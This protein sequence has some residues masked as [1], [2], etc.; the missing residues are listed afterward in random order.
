MNVL[1][2]TQLK[3]GGSVI[4][5]D[6]SLTV[7]FDEI[8]YSLS[9]GA[10][11]GGFHHTLGVRNQKLM[12]HIETE[13]DLPGGSAAKYM[14]DEMELMGIPVNFATAI[15]TSA[16]MA[17]HVYYC[18]EVEDVIV[19]VILTAGYDKTAHRAGDGYCYEE[20]NGEFHAPGTI[21]MLLFTNKALTDGAMAKA[22]ITIAEA[23]SAVLSSREVKDVLTGATAT[24]TAT[25][26][27]ILTIDTNG[28]ILTDA[29]TF[30]L[31]GDTLA[32]AVREALTL[33]LEI[34]GNDKS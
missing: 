28:E 12:Y 32:K 5:T 29:G 8:H 26:G 30:S 13:K 7:M 19:E 20:R 18:K 24:G 27:I 14:G 6:S 34:Y 21:N 17:K 33:S 16:D 3:T 15:M 23:K 31:F 25:D 22:F 2:P 9:T 11:N 10:L 4:V 1:A